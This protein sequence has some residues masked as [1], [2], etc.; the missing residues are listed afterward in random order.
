MVIVMIIAA[1]SS[2]A[3]PIFLSQR[4]K[5]KATEAQNKISTIVRQAYAEFQL[6]NDEDDAILSA[7]SNAEQA[8]RAGNFSYGLYKAGGI[9]AQEIVMATEGIDLL[10]NDTLIIGADPTGAANIDQ[11]LINS[12]TKEPLKS[13][14]IFGCI[15]LLSGKSDIKRNFKDAVALGNDGS[16]ETA[17]TAGLD[18]S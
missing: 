4:D 13:G 3:L 15:N 10:P 5:A 17:S 6:N 14:K 18:C 7:I 8:N 12:S 16:G 9:A 1:L 2:V 11:E